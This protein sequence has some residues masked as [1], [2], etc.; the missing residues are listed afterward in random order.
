M[1]KVSLQF[2]TLPELLNFTLFADVMHCQ[3]IKE[4][5]VLNCRL[6]EAQIEL[7]RA[8]F[9]A[10]VITELNKESVLQENIKSAFNHSSNGDISC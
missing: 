1:E 8:G 2:P 3:I 4:T 10:T 6:S 7:A 9:H 5:F